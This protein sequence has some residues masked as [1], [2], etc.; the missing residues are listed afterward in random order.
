MESVDDNSINFICSFLLNVDI[1][2]IPKCD[3]I[4]KLEA[5]QLMLS[6]THFF[7]SPKVVRS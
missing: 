7:D 2:Q 3:I 5:F 1:P 4:S 6:Y